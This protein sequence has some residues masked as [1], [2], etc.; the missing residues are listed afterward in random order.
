MVS[1]YSSLGFYAFNHF[2]DQSMH[3]RPSEIADSEWEALAS[4]YQEVEEI[5]LFVGGLAETQQ[6]G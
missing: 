2:P 5:D 3:S 6:R 4:V 1:A